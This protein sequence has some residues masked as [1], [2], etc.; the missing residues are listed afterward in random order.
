MK[1]W[2]LYVLKSDGIELRGQFFYID[3]VQVVRNSPTSNVLS[4]KIGLPDSMSQM[5][6]LTGRMVEETLLDFDRT[7]LQR[8][9]SDQR[10]TWLGDRLWKV[11]VMKR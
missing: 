9:L 11:T 10:P 6:L 5:V 4:L 8:V 2:V 3:G 7:I 1:R